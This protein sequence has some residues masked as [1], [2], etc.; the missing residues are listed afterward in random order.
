VLTCLNPFITAEAIELVEELKHCTLYFPIT[1]LIRVKPLGAY[2]VKLINKDDGWC[3]LL[4]QFERVS[5]E[6]GPIT[7]EH[8][9]Q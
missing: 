4:S 3:L 2:C 7:N 9:N 6:L 8:L 5:D 1:A